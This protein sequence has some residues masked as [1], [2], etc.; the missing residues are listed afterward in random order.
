[1]V[2]YDFTN[3][4]PQII[5]LPFWLFVSARPRQWLKNLALYATIVF[6]GEFFNLD[7]F[8][9]TTLGFAIFCLVTCR[10]QRTR[11]GLKFLK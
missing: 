7:K 6:E 10:K 9:L 3:R 8:L 4:G 5:W 11:G 1:M 2:K